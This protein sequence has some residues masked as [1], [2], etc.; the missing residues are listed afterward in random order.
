MKNGLKL[1]ATLLTAGLV[2]LG[3]ASVKSP[4]LS[5]TPLL[6]QALTPQQISA[7]AKEFTVRIDG[8]DYGSG[9]IVARNRN[10]YSVLTNWHV[11]KESGQYTVQT[12]DGQSHPV[13]SKKE[14][15]GADLAVVYFASNNE[16]SIA[17][18]GNSRQLAEGQTVHLAGY[19]APQPEVSNRTY[20]FD[21][22]NLMGFLSPSDI[23]DGY[24]LIY[25]GAGLLGLSGGPIL[26]SNGQLIGINGRVVID[27]NTGQISLY[28]IPINTVSRLAIRAG[29][30]LGEPVVASSPSLS[31]VTTALRD[32]SGTWE[33]DINQRGAR[34]Y[35]GIFSF[36]VADSNIV[37]KSQYPE[38]NCGGELQLLS[39][40]NQT[41]KFQE[42][43][44]YGTSRCISGLTKVFFLTSPTTINYSNQAY[45]I[46]AILNKVTNPAI[47]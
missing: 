1:I 3:I 37:G 45:S 34:P 14:I 17:G 26:N 18:K 42:T 6:V 47:E 13:S 29:I 15:R 44:T 35:S 25:R 39:M 10:I 2:G 33:G 11:V 38:L 23:K 12:S 8:Q 32:I 46:T 31:P 28:G 16:Y 20:H 9:A 41:Y 22:A 4:V 27:G 5:G 43:I 30:N 36:S 24:E 19:P 40:D 7:R 21:S